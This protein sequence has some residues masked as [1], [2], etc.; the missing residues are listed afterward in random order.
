MGWSHS[1]ALIMPFMS[2]QGI[3]LGSSSKLRT[4]GSKYQPSL[5]SWLPLSGLW[6]PLL[7]SSLPGLFF[8]ASLSQVQSLQAAFA[9][10][11]PHRPFLQQ[12]LLLGS[13]SDLLHCPQSFLFP[14]LVTELCRARLL[15]RLGFSGSNGGTPRTYFCHSHSCWS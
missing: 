6:P 13:F 2:F 4:L 5:Q 12:G 7:F 11:F 15:Y 9:V 1:K 8:N 10:C 3:G 14:T